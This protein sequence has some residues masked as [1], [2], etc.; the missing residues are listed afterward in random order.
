MREDLF[1]LVVA[2]HLPIWVR[3]RRTLRTR[4][5]THTLL[6]GE[7]VVRLVRYPRVNILVIMLLRLT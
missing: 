1:A 2:R 7:V 6:P 3:V 5:G 4:V